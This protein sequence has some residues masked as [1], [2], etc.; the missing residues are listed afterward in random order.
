M[1]D[2]ALALCRE[3]G[4]PMAADKTE[5]PVTQLTFLGIEIDTVAM[6][7][8]LSAEK[9][10]D[11]QQLITAWVGKKTASLTEYMSLSGVLNFACG[12]VAAGKPFCR[13]LIQQQQSLRKA[14]WV[15][16]DAQQ[17]DIPH[18]VREDL[19]WWSEWLPE[20]NGKSLL[21]D[22][23][24]SDAPKIE[25]FTDAC[26]VGFGGF[27][28]NAWFAGRWSPEQLERAYVST[29]I[30]IPFLELLALVTAAHI[31]AHEWRG[32]KITFRC[33]AAAVVHALAANRSKRPALMHLIRELAKLACRFGFTYRV[34][35]IAGVNN[36]VADVLSR[37]GDCH[38][39]RALRPYADRRPQRIPLIRLIHSMEEETD[40]VE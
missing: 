21:L 6:E 8:R 33:D 16:S 31:W 2:R 32:K 29:R 35:H 7:A 27:Y 18:Y 9:L 23:E 19:R 20:W 36:D 15:K 22:Q 4:I 37:Y 26:D 10:A 25:L 28:Q 30:S 13:R 14:A 39:F 5:G 1:R 17:T 11:L 12:V 24:W 38:Q 40:D 3:L 34:E